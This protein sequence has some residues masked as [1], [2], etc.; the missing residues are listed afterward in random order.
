MTRRR[1]F[2]SFH[3]QDVINFRANVV[4]NHYVMQKDDASY[5]DAS[6]WEDAKKHGDIALKRLIN[7]GLNR[8]TVTAV[9]IGTETFDRRWVR[10]EIMKSLARDNKV[11][12]VH[13]NSIAGL[14]GEKKPLGV[15]PFDYLGL[16]ISKDGSMATPIEYRNNKCLIYEDIDRFS[17]ST[18]PLSE[19]GN[20]YKLSEWLKVYDWVADSGFS[21][22]GNW[23]Q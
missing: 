21:N 18:R 1:V 3:Y 5:F 19:R 6:I 9:L 11:I 22:F 4:R 16:I 8:T 2:F 20:Q 7:S 13:I 17:I 14:N 12:G 10:Y 15:N 23:I